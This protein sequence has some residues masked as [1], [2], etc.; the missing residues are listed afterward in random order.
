M[1]WRCVVLFF[2]CNQPKS[3]YYSNNRELY[4]SGFN[5]I[6]RRLTAT[7]EVLKDIKILGSQ[8]MT[9]IALLWKFSSWFMRNYCMVL[10]LSWSILLSKWD[11]I[12]FWHFPE[13]WKL[14]G[15]KQLMS[16]S[17]GKNCH[18]GW[19]CSSILAMKISSSVYIKK[20]PSYNDQSSEHLNRNKSWPSILIT[21]QT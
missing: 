5:S 7:T 20:I 2:T 4:T 9:V 18:S 13:V 11:W 1:S 16:D 15:L 6:C 21:L 8:N 17:Q 19:W 14:R 10:V 3:W 12:M